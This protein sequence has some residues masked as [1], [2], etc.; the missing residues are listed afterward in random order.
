MHPSGCF[1]SCPKKQEET[2]ADPKKYIEQSML[3]RALDYDGYYGSQC[4]DG[5][6]FY[7]RD[8]AGAPFCPGAGAHE[9]W[10]KFWNLPIADYYTPALVPSVG[11]VAVWGT[12]WG[13]GYGHVGIVYETHADGTFTSAECNG[14]GNP[15]GECRLYHRGLDGVLGFLVPKTIGTNTTTTPT[16]EPIAEPVGG[17]YHVIAP[18]ETLGGIAGYY[19]KD[20]RELAAVNQLANPDHII[21]GSTLYIP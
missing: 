13:G 3:G 20:W 16:V 2:L 17:F 4:F 10:N 7:N 11:A 14:D 5:F 6:Q 18:G 9:I 12:T 21:A 15:Y 8:V 1:F 19:G